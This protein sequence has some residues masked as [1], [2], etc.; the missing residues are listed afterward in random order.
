VAYVMTDMLKGVITRGTGRGVA[1]FGR[2][3]AGKT[4]TTD[5]Y[6]NA[7][8]IAFTPQV[9]TGVWVGNDDNSATEKV[10]GASVP[11]RIW[12]AYMQ[13]ALEKM[14]ETDWEVPPGVTV[15]TVCGTSGLLATSSCDDPRHEA[16]ISGT[17]PTDYMLGESSEVRLNRGWTPGGTP[18]GGSSGT[19]SGGTDTVAGG[20]DRPAPPQQPQPFILQVLTP[21]DGQTVTSPFTIEGATVPG[22]RVQIVVAA[23]TATG[24]VDTTEGVVAAMRD[25]R[26]KYAFWPRSG[27]AVKYTIRVSAHI[28]GGQPAQTTITVIEPS[29]PPQDGGDMNR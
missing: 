2:P 7:W 27:P 14:P 8:F 22:A 29:P 19:P 5:D 23:E 10:V 15:V 25:G 13:V 3:L 16:F 18:Q 17:E 1:D 21:L 11:L 4:G 9:V 28:R 6:R 20:G 26:F 24:E 12:K